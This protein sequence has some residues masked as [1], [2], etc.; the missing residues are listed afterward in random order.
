LPYIWGNYGVHKWPHPKG[1][2]LIYSNQGL[3]QCS[4]PP[5]EQTWHH[6]Y[7]LSTG[8]WQIEHRAECFQQLVHLL[9]IIAASP[10]RQ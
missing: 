5:W 9:L 1:H 2:S 10:E 8:R 7:I 6:K 4:C 3:K